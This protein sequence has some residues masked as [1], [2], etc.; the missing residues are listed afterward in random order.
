[1][2]TRKFRN[3]RLRMHS[4]RRHLVTGSVA[5]SAE[6]EFLGKLV[7]FESSGAQHKAGV[8]LNLIFEKQKA[9]F[10]NARFTD[11]SLHCKTSNLLL[12]SSQLV[13][14]ATAS[15]EV[16]VATIRVI[17]GD[18]P[19]DLYPSQAK[20]VM[21][22]IRAL[23]D[24]YP[25]RFR[26]YSDLCL[27]L[28]ETLGGPALKLMCPTSSLVTSSGET[29]ILYLE[30]PDKCVS[31]TV[32]GGENNSRKSGPY[33]RTFFSD[34]EILSFCELHGA[35]FLESPCGSRVTSLKD[36]VN[37]WSYKVVDMRWSS[38]DSW[39]AKE[40]LI[41]EEESKLSLLSFIEKSGFEDA[42]CLSREFSFKTED[43][44][45]VKQE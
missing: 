24:Q 20:N 10:G 2:I 15:L 39:I 40:S 41:Q 5:C 36:L 6:F 16:R 13:D 18:S 27:K 23:I 4:I 12:S 44:R 14:L 38:V 21:D 34:N 31:L 29:T 19:F 8:V 25:G 42:S 35:A 1:M 45:N 32:Y 26:R 43:G 30:V 11:L 37:S 22:I 9:L 33:S 17:H 28:T 3:F 7:P